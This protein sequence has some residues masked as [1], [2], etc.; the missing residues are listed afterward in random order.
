[1]KPTFQDMPQTH[2][3]TSVFV[4]ARNVLS[5]KYLDFR[6]ATFHSCNELPKQLEAEEPSKLVSCFK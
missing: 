4:P 6:P 1:M 2:N 5:I 3:E